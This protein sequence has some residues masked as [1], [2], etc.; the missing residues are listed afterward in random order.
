MQPVL[1]LRPSDARAF[2]NAGVMLLIL[3]RFDEAQQVLAH[4]LQLAP[5][6]AIYWVSLVSAALRACDWETLEPFSSPAIAGV[7]EGKAGVAPVEP[8]GAVGRC[9]FCRDDVRSCNQHRTS[10]GRRSGGRRA[11]HGAKQPIAHDRIRI[12]YLSSDFGDHPVAAQIVG[13]LERHDRSRFR[14]RRSVYRTD[15]GSGRYHRIVK[16]CDHFSDHR[17]PWAAARPPA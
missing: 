5:N 11:G 2:Y 9:R 10:R 8:A 17:R 7:R 12:G 3:N 4:A 6:Q 1:Q 14:S 13:L 16:A 15:D